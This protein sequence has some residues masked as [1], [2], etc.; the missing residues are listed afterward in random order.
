MRRATQQHCLVAQLR[1]HV[2]LRIARPARPGAPCPAKPLPAPTRLVPSAPRRP[3]PRRHAPRRAAMPRPALCPVSPGPAPPRANLCRP[4]PHAPLRPAPTGLAPSRP[5]SPRVT[6]SRRAP[7]C[8]V[9]CR[10]P[11]P[12]LRTTTCTCRAG[13]DGSD[14]IAS[15]DSLRRAPQALA[16][17]GSSRAPRRP[18]RAATHRAGGKR[19][20]N[21]KWRATLF[22]YKQLLQ[23]RYSTSPH[24]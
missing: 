8:P 20:D 22:N 13:G 7:P 6:L 1:R 14:A 11:C 23:L 21:G 2:P 18:P 12:A 17:R 10:T 5:A 24:V 9:L 3:A 15:N 19:N 4:A 16:A